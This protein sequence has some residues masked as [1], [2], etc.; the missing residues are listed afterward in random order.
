MSDDDNGKKKKLLTPDVE[1]QVK[2]LEVQESDMIIPFRF[3]GYDSVILMFLIFLGIFNRFWLLWSPRNMVTEDK[4]YLDYIHCYAKNQFCPTT[5]PPL[6]AIMLRLVGQ[7]MEY[8]DSYMSLKLN[9]EYPTTVYHSIRS[10]PAFFSFMSIPAS[11]FA[12]RCFNIPIPFAFLGSICL[13]CEHSLVASSRY[14][15]DRGI[16][17][18]MVTATL[19]FCSFSMHFKT[20]SPSQYILLI[21]QMIFTGCSISISWLALPIYAFT[22]FWTIS[23]SKS[24]KTRIYS[25]LIP[26]LIVYFS[27]LVSLLMGF[28]K[29]PTYEKYSSFISKH[30]TDSNVI[31]LSGWHLVASL[32]MMLKTGFSCLKSLI[33]TKI[34]LFLSKLF[35][36]E[37]WKVV[38][39]E[40]ERRAACFTNRF[41]TIP[42]LVYNVLFAYESIRKRSFNSQSL[43]AFLFVISHLFYALSDTNNGPLDS[44]VSIITCFICFPLSIN[45]LMRQSS[46]YFF[47]VSM[48]V[49]SIISFIDLCTLVYAYFDPAPVLPIWFAR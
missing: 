33:H 46:G 24:L 34:F 32:I 3:D 8:N 49:I 41:T 43:I 30:Q 36:L 23:K 31:H 10:I 5:Q 42:A 38:W 25:V 15:G 12:I 16:C 47:C 27:F 20:D 48:I 11:Y 35:Y 45:N 37:K 18:F 14:I 4:T 1:N 22:I 17:H 44:Y 39:Q 6:G 13:M 2:I 9:E 21:A 26:L 29:N 19:M 40:N 7:R 28:K